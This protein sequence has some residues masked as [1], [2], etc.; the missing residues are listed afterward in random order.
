[1]QQNKS[2]KLKTFLALFLIIQIVIIR[3]LPFFPE[4]V[5]RFY[6]NGLYSITSKSLRY[7]FGWLPFSF[8]D[9]FYGVLLF[10]AIRWG[11]KNRKRIFKDTKTWLIDVISTISLVYF[12]FHIFWGFNYYRLPIHKK[13]NIDNE[14]S[15]EALI[16][17]TKQLI[18]KSNTLHSQLNSNDTLRVEFPYSKKELLKKIPLG[19]DALSKTYPHLA[20]NAVSIKTSLFSLPLTYQGFSGYLNPISNEAQVDGLIPIFKYAT[21]ASHEVAH[22]LGYA[23]ENEANFIGC[24]ATIHHEDIYINYA[25]YTFA[26]RHCLSEIYRRSYFKKLS[27]ST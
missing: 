22:Q 15:T 11:I 14:Y 13:L 3:C 19:Y 6:S 21:T 5:E 10:L 27:R 20:Y 18:I 12:A 17:V 8:G 23:A 26:L 2:S 25:G 4:I 24:L 1:M 16:E 9:I 7:A